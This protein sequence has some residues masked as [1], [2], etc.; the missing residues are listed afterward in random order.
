MGPVPPIGSSLHFSAPGF[1]LGLRLAQGLSTGEALDLLGVMFAMMGLLL[2]LF[3]SATAVALALTAVSVFR[4][5]GSSRLLL[6]VL[7]FLLVV[8]LL[9]MLGYR[10]D[11]PMVVALVA[12][13]A[14]LAL[15]WSRPTSNWLCEVRMRESPQ[16][17]GSPAY[18]S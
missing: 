14:G 5:S 15:T 6:T 10:A 7:T 18:P 11:W 12:G 9:T 2:S 4:G 16:G 1:G 3:V 13:L 17:R 8:G